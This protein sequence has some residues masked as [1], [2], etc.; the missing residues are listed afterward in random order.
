V[1]ISLQQKRFLNCKAN[2]T[3]IVWKHLL[4]S[5]TL[6]NEKKIYF[7]FN[8]LLF[9]TF[10]HL[11]NRSGWCGWWH[12]GEVDGW[13][14]WEGHKF[15]LYFSIRMFAFVVSRTFLSESLS[16]F[17]I[18]FF[19]SFAPFYV[20][21]LTSEIRFLIISVTSSLVLFL[22]RFMLEDVLIWALAS[23]GALISSHKSINIRRVIM[24]SNQL[25]FVFAW[26]PTA[27]H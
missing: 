17:S 7:L 27:T 1:A 22:L 23:L 2:W 13:R 12:R 6:L 14:M 10:S 26:W 11:E 20:V 21:A 9:F 18:L 24:T 3:E 5:K 25:V 16:S 15:S 4:V 19:H 8:F